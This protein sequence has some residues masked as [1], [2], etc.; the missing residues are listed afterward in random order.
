MLLS[1]A[2]VQ[3]LTSKVQNVR[4]SS[5]ELKT[6]MRDRLVP[7][8][9][10]QLKS[11]KEKSD[12]VLGQTTVGN[13]LGGMRG[14]RCMLW[15]G[16]ELDAE[17]GITFHGKTISECNSV[18]P[19]GAEQGASQMLPESM[20][21]LIMTGEVPTEKQIRALST[22]LA[23]Q[24]ALPAHVDDL[25]RSMPRDI[26][27]M[28][29]LSS[30]VAT[31]S[32][33]SEFARQYSMG[34]VKK[35]QFWEPTFDDSISLL[36]KIPAIAARIYNH[37]K[38]IDR[39][40]VADQNKDVTWN[41]AE[42]I[43]FGG[44]QAFREM[45]RLYL[46]L[47][48]DHEGGNVSAHSTHLVG[49]ALSDPFLS[50]SAGLL[51]LAGPLHGLAAQD[52]LRFILKMHEVM[53]ENYGDAD[54]EKYLWEFLNSGRVVPGYG[55]AV[56]RQPDPRFTALHQFSKNSSTI[57]KDA[58]WKLVDTVSRIAPQVLKVHG[59]TKNPFPN[60][61]SQS[62]VLLHHYGLKETEFYTVIFGISRAYGV[63]PQ[64]VWDR[65]L[66]LPIERPKSL[67]IKALQQ[68]V[69]A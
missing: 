24:S 16:S 42:N 68:I 23:R 34:S 36:A 48:A 54:V 63:L 38:G 58:H 53:P 12:S 17:R 52:V 9:R 11:L 45:M 44:D 56:L 33:N 27:P 3:R 29:A 35:E 40:Y 61:D 47:H 49:S 2:A 50:Y 20:M 6:A 60:V 1:R 22:D 62:G 46:A 39:K 13:L 14:L 10:Q 64:L 28:T 67:S 43:G 4:F 37:S 19:H 65:V 30:A 18:L 66:N 8:K 32:H 57:S 5:T 15:E 25:I 51:G 26:H 55:H 31:L 59:K 21:W 69:H 7:I 41:F